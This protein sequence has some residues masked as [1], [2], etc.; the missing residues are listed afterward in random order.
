[1]HVH[2]HVVE[3]LV[4]RKLLLA[5]LLVCWSVAES[6]L[7]DNLLLVLAKLVVLLRVRVEVVLTVDFDHRTH[8]R[9][10]VICL[11]EMV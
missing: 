11:Q 10:V 1:M 5:T 7:S 3:C 6:V 4:Y 9:D 2:I 8:S